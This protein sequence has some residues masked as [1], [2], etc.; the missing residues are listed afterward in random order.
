MSSD[1]VEIKLFKTILIT[2]S[3]HW[4]KW[5][6]GELFHHSLP[7]IF[8]PEIELS[9]QLPLVF[10]KLLDPHCSWCLKTNHQKW[11]HAP[12]C[13]FH[14]DKRQIQYRVQVEQL[15]WYVFHYFLGP[16][17]FHA[18]DPE[19][20]ILPFS[21]DLKESDLFDFF[22]NSGLS[23]PCRDWNKA[24]IALDRLDYP[25]RRNSN[26][27]IFI[28]LIESNH[29]EVVEIADSIAIAESIWQL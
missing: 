5:S 20:E 7:D 12:N 16:R 13:V 18:L 28:L 2:E 21:V 25:T 4:Q 9:L 11:S 24:E 22:V 8:D 23:L 29:L 15:S 6:L 10:S 14:F 3:L 27:I 17:P 1:F 26:I 19:S